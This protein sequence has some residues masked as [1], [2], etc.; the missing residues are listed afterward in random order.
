[1]ATTPACTPRALSHDVQAIVLKTFSFVESWGD[2]FI[3]NLQTLV[4]TY[5]VAVGLT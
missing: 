4:C 5:A 2:C 1:M 3:A